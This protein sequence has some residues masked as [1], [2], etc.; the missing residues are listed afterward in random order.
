MSTEAAHL[1]CLPVPVFVAPFV[2]YPVFS[3]EIDEQ[4][5]DDHGRRSFNQTVIPL[6]QASDGFVLGDGLVS[7]VS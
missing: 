5:F 1:V 7:F 4:F 3:A 2:S 6:P